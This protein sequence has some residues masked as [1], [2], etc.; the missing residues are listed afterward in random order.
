MDQE[1]ILR[2]LSDLT[3]R[4]IIRHS[5]E[6]VGFRDR[7]LI[8]MPLGELA[9][10]GP[11]SLVQSSRGQLTVEVGENLLGRVLDRLGRPFDGRGPLNGDAQYPLQNSPPDPWRGRG[12]RASAGGWR[13]I[14]GLLTCSRASELEF[15]LAAASGK[16]PC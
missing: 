2:D 1:L 13:A 12:L 15:S 6:V 14:D 11:G 5:A 3:E 8:L 9:G 4:P 7:Q 10:V 16:A